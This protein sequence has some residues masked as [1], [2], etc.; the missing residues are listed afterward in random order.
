MKYNIVIKIPEITIPFEADSDKEAVKLGWAGYKH[1][2]DNC[3]GVFGV[4]NY[5]VEDE[6]G[7]SI[8]FVENMPK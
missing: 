5:V 2:L 6:D 1:Y 8:V 7:D 3:R 4:N